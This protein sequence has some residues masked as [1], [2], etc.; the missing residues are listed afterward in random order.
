[1][2][3]RLDFGDGVAFSTRRAQALEAVLTVGIRD[4]GHIDWVAQ[5]IESGQQQSDAGDAMFAGIKLAIVVLVA[6]NE[7]ANVGAVDV[8]DGRTSVDVVIDA[9]GQHINILVS[10]SAG[11]RDDKG[12]AVRA[13]DR[14]VGGAAEKRLEIVLDRGQRHPAGWEGHG[15]AVRAVIEGEV[16]HRIGDNDELLFVGC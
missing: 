10:L 9:A 11:E 4:D 14:H 13:G 15:G 7:A 8:D 12:A 5:M 3:G 1:M 16:R 6:V 2:A